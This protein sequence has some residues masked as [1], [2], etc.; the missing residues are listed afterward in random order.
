M[1][2]NPIRFKC[3]SLGPDLPNP[4]SEHCLVR[5]ND[6]HLFL[7]FGDGVTR[8]SFVYNRVTGVWTKMPE[9]KR[10]RHRRSLCGYAEREGFNGEVVRE[11]IVAGGAAESFAERASEILDLVMTN[12]STDL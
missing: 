11:V 1:F 7:A 12:D 5:L 4:S 2:Q 6:T 3:T 8:D 10:F 9:T